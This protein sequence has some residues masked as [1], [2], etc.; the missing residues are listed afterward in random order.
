MAYREKLLA[1]CINLKCRVVKIC[2]MQNFIVHKSIPG[3]YSLNGSLTVTKSVLPWHTQLLIHLTQHFLW[4]QVIAFGYGLLWKGLRGIFLF[5]FKSKL[6]P[7][8]LSNRLTFLSS[9]FRLSKSPG[10]FP[11]IVLSS[12]PQGWRGWSTEG[13]K[14]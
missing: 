8:F 1:L 7:S 3:C 4:L 13:R 5:W 2:Q 10:P 9:P 12:V 14:V 6:I 11:P